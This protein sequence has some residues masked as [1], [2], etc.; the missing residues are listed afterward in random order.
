MNTKFESKNPLKWS[1]CEGKSVAGR[2]IL[3]FIIYNFG[4]SHD[5]AVEMDT[6]YEMYGR[7]V[8]VRVPVGA[9]FFFTSSRPVLGLTQPPI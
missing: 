4:R 9:I 2:I 3:K 7:G 5:S 8:G 1:T 6:G